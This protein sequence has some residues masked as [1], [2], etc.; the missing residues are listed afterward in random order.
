MQIK[1]YFT[2]DIKANELNEKV[3]EMLTNLFKELNGLY[4]TRFVINK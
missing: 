1:E 3:N 4:C 2:N